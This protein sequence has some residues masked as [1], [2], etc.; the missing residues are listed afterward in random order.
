MTKNR[1]KMLII[2]LTLVLIIGLVAS[3]VS[4]TYPLSVN[5]VKYK[6]SS[7]VNELVLG[8]DISKGVIIEYE[9]S[10]RDNYADD[11]SFDTLMDTTLTGIRGILNDSGFKNSTVTRNGQKGVRVEVGGIVNKDDSSEV[12]NLIGSPKQLSFSSS[13]S[14]DDAFMTG[15]CVK[16]VEAKQMSNGSQTAYFVEITFTNKGYEIIKEKSAEIINNSEGEGK[17]YMLLGSTQIGSSSEVVTTKSIS[18]S[19]ETFI[20]M[21]TTKQYAIQIRTGMLPLNLI[22]SY[23]GTISASS[24][25]RGLITNPMLYIWVALG[26]MVIATLVFFVLRYKQL[27]LI[28]MFN[29]L[30]Y[31]VLGLFFLQSVPLVHINF[32]GILGIVLGY[33]LAVIALT[34]TLENA[35]RE[36]AKGKKLHTSLHQGIN[37]SLS[38]TVTINVMFV[39]AGIVCA[40]MPSMAIQSFGLVSLVLGFVNVFCSQALMRLMINLYL[41][42]NSEDGSKCNFTKEEGIK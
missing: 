27:G 30:F 12:I 21:Q 26:I 38:S 4:F 34:S 17:F 24:G 33:V 40:L 42:F 20:D 6:Y 10:V 13:T 31:I 3:F 1:S 25:I 18:M 15:E 23:N 36:Y 7:F 29:M 16:S 19:S 14:P 28:A 5:G 11:E 2:F 8:S 32:S 35:K 37:A 22:C 41:P 9:A 39:L